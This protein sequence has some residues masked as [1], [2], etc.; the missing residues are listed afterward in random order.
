MIFAAISWIERHAWPQLHRWLDADPDATLAGYNTY[1]ENCSFIVITAINASAGFNQ[2]CKWMAWRFAIKSRNH[3]QILN[4]IDT[5]TDHEPTPQLLSF[6]NREYFVFRTALLVQKFN[7][8][9]YMRNV[10]DI[11]VQGRLSENYLT[12]NFKFIP[13]NINF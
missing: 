6:C 3:F 12:W 5:S 8:Q 2:L 7:T 10:N 4:A 11:A 9:K 1:L 13:W